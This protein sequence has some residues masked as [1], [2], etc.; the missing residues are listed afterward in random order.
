M[1]PAFHEGGLISYLV[2]VAEGEGVGGVPDWL[3][4]GQEDTTIR[5]KSKNNS[6]SRFVKVRECGPSGRAAARYCTYDNQETF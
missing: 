1:S 2:D 5:S 6:S 3:L 4:G